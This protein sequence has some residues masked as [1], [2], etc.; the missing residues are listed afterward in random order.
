MS[1][2]GKKKTIN[3]DFNSTYDPRSFLSIV[4]KKNDTHYLFV[5]ERKCQLPHFFEP[6]PKKNMMI[7]ETTI[8]TQ[9]REKLGA[10]SQP[11]HICTRNCKIVC[12]RIE[13][14]TDG[15]GAYTVVW[16]H[17]SSKIKRQNESWVNGSKTFVKRVNTIFVCINS[18]LVHHCM[19][20]CTANTIQTN[21]DTEICVISKIQWHKRCKTSTGW[22][23]Q[24]K[25]RVNAPVVKGDPLLYHRDANGRIRLLS[26]DYNVKFE[27]QKRIVKELLDSLMF[28][29]ERIR[30]ELSRNTEAMKIASKDILKYIR[31]TR[32]K[33]GIVSFPVTRVIKMQHIAFMSSY[34]S[35]MADYKKNQFQT[36]NNTSELIAKYYTKF[37][38]LGLVLCF[39]NFAI[40]VIYLMRNGIKIDGKVIIQAIP[41]LAV[42]L[43][44]ANLLHNFKDLVQKSI[45]TDAKNRITALIRSNI[46]TLTQ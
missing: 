35:R 46:E 22:K 31:A 18:R 13:I 5:Y 42:K 32:K 34:L 40:A 37:S 24:S 16:P 17:L 3:V 29:P 11:N 23:S 26:A 43:P 9:L 10:N 36:V 45:F 39:Q 28:S 15:N 19:P 12:P 27:R 30:L 7:E 41:M 25:C 6:L 20:N 1:E 21:N 44:P 33:G 2:T 14:H 38:K 4:C 8:A